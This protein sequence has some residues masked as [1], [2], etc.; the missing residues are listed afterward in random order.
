MRAGTLIADHV[1]GNNLSMFAPRVEQGIRLHRRIDALVDTSSAVIALKPL[2]GAPLRRYAGILFDIFFDHALIGD[3]SSYSSTPLDRFTQEI[4][5][6]LANAEAMMPP[7][8]S[9]MAKR[10][11]QFD[12]LTSCSTIA[13]CANTLDRIA[14]RLKRPVDLA[15]AVN[16]LEQHHATIQAALHSVLPVLQAA[17]C[18]FADVVKPECP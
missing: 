11:R 12:T 15:V 14:R 17:A 1:R 10:M 2:V 9:S 18:D 13:G 3:W 16:T 8:T 4:Y 7:A 6:D 5:L